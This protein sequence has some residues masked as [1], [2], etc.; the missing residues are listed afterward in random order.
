MEQGRSLILGLIV[1]GVDGIAVSLYIDV[2]YSVISIKF[3]G[4][5]VLENSAVNGF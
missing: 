2:G 1:F 5:P 4:I 3:C